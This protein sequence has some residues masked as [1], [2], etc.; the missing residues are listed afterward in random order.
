MEGWI[1][2]AA[3]GAAL[4][5]LLAACGNSGDGNEFPQ[6][7]EDLSG[8]TAQSP[9]DGSSDGD[10]IGDA[11]N[12]ALG[13]G[14]GGMLIIDGEEIPITTVT[15]MMDDQSFDAGTVSENGFRVLATKTRPENDAYVQILD[16]EFL[17]WFQ[18]DSTGDEVQRDGNTLRGATAIYSNTEDDRQFEASFTIECP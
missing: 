14:G 11:L 18:K 15:C 8:Q 3:V 13:N 1:R 10:D 17:Q 12:N 16:A 4:M 5:L 7:A 6:T 2:R 9:I